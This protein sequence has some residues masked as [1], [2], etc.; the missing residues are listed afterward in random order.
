MRSDPN[1]IIE[2]QIR[3]RPTKAEQKKITPPAKKN[4][5]LGIELPFDWC[6][7]RGRDLR[8]LQKELHQAQQTAAMRL[9]ICANL[10]KELLRKD[11]RCASM[12][13]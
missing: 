9:R 6:L 5:I 10:Q 13:D 12:Y 11:S 2:R 7:V 3:A 8:A 1:E 4:S